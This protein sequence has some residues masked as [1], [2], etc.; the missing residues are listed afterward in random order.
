MRKEL[1]SRSFRDKMAASNMEGL[2]EFNLIQKSA[3]KEFFLIDS[4]YYMQPF[5]WE[6]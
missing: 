3:K 5:S 6:S 2:L 4:D 1:H